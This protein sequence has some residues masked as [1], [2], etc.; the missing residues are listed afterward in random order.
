MIG[1][2]IVD[3]R[4][5]KKESNWQRLHFLQKVFTKEEQHFI[6][7]SSDKDAAVWLLWTGKESVYK[8][9]SRLE[10]RRFFAPKKIQ[11]DIR[12]DVIHRRGRACPASVVSAEDSIPMK[13]SFEQYNFQTKSTV[14]DTH[15]HTIAQSYNNSEPFTSDCFFIA[16]NNYQTQHQT[17][18]KYLLENYA[19]MANLA[20]AD[21]SIQKDR[22]QIPY[23]YYKNKKQP[24][25]ISI[26]HHGNYGGYVIMMNEKR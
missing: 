9:I 19:K 21:L 3:L 10:K 2:D 5:A 15:I 17:T 8:I 6:H 16:K 1:N 14:T 23:L 11:H 20:S 7:T 25:M 24:V 12:I 13:I 18:R 22:H 4:F 26:S